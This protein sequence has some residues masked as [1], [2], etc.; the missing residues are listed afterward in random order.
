LFVTNQAA[1]PG[2]AIKR[3]L[4]ERVLSGVSGM[5]FG[6]WLRLLMKHR[7]K[8]DGPYWPRASFVTGASFITSVCCAYE[9]R[10]HVASALKTRVEAPL[11]ILGHWRSGTTYLHN[12]LALDP[13]FAYPTAYEVMN[14]HTFLATERWS[15]FVQFLT[16]TT[17]MVDNVKLDLDVP[18][19]DEF[20]TC[21]MTFRSPYMSWVFPSC[22]HDYDRYLTFAEV[23]SKEL[24]E[25]KSAIRLFLGKLTVKHS[26]PLLLK[27]P[28][29]TCRIRLLLDLFPD[30]RFVHIYRNPYAVFQST[31]H[32]HA[33]M[34]RACR[35]QRSDDQPIEE[36]VIA[37]YQV[38]YERFF[39]ERGLIPASRFHELSFEEL[40]RDPVGQMDRIYQALEIEGFNSVRPVLERYV[41]SLATYKKNQY[42]ELGPAIRT[43][44]ARAWQ[45]SF[46]EWGY[47]A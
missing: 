41:A 20:A 32:L 24:A 44:V 36:R 43:R 25:W 15:R 30:A 10:V 26:R 14:P 23:S 27:S 13:Q 21:I 19:E 29:H 47:A 46:H 17:R 38:M 37:Q 12:L 35:L 16:P 28:P 34:Y 7:W 42:S 40:E 18:L 45:R 8:I 33:F 31:N 39:Q 22:A 3:L 4:A 2:D 9:N 5:T 1:N 6:N 11:F